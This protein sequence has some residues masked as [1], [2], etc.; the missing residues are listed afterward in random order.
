MTAKPLRVCVVGAGS[1]SREFALHHFGDATS[2]RVTSIVDLN[3]ERA[4]VLARDVGAVQAGATVKNDGTAYRAMASEIIGKPTAHA[5]S[6]APVLELCDIVYIGTTPGAHAPL[7]LEALNAGKHIL[8]EKPL[9]ATPEDAD[10]IVKASVEA[11][12]RGQWLGMNIGMRWNP[13]L[14]EL[15]RLAVVERALGELKTGR[16][17]M[18]YTMWPREWQVQPWCAGRGEGG[19]LREVGT[20]FFF[21]I[22]ECFG[23]G[24]VKRVKTEVLYADG[25]GGTASEIS[26]SG[27]LELDSGLLISLDVR[28]DSKVGDVYELEVVG[29]KGSLMLDSFCKLR[30][31]AP[32]T[33]WLM[34]RGSYGRIESVTTL[35][36]AI[37]G[38]EA[39]DLIT[40]REGRNAQRLL[41]A[42]LISG[43]EWL[44]V[45][46]D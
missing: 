30:R 6:L 17:S 13:A 31:T 44:E 45:S 20:H 5:T 21:G 14:H 2:T 37:R 10:I 33:E 36:S 40:A 46:Y 12:D 41:D 29:E 26:A 9:A 38:G 23:H 24:C 19:P 3:E 35:V 25:P 27:T 18:H 15:R 8:L 39:G 4:Q 11:A 28:T 42:I 16:L 32:T 34:Q 22:M 7:V 1:I 43:G